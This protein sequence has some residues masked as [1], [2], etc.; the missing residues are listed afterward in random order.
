MSVLKGLEVFGDGLRI[1]PPDEL[2]V[3]GASEPLITLGN[4]RFHAD[5]RGLFQKPMHVGTV[6]VGRMIIAIPPK[7]IRQKGANAERHLGKISIVVDEIDRKHITNTG[8]RPE[9]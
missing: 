4:F 5:L 8:E 6:R 1:Y 3:A 2:V 7:Q 9:G